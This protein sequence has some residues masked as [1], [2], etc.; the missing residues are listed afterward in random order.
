MTMSEAQATAQWELGKLVHD[1]DME[2]NAWMRERVTQLGLT[3]A[4]ASALREL[5]GPMTMRELAGQMSCE[6]SNATVVIDKLE[7]LQLIERRSHPTDRRAKQLHLTP[8][9]AERRKRLLKL[10]SQEPVVVG[11]TPQ[12]Q[13]VLQNLLRRAIAARQAS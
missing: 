10:L 12:E 6:P 4:Q 9:G 13:D 5:T 3:V 1:L 7:S 8:D 11:L 2:S